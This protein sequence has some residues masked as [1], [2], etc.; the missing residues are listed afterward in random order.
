MHAPGSPYNNGPGNYK[1]EQNHKRTVKL[2]YQTLSLI[3]NDHKL[4]TKVLNN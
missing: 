2:Q 4:I 3:R 1:C